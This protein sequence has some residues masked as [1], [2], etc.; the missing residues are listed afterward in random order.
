MNSTKHLKSLFPIFNFWIVEFPQKV[1]KFEVKGTRNARGNVFLLQG[2]A[3]QGQI[4][5]GGAGNQSN[6]LGAE[7]GGMGQS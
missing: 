1:I 6:I 7:W 4:P 3:G 2:G 5:R